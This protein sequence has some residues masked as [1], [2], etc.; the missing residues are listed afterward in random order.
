MALGFFVIIITIFLISR[1]FNIVSFLKTSS[2]VRSLARL[3]IFQFGFRRILSA[4]YFKIN[5]FG[6]SSLGL[7]ILV[8]RLLSGEVF[9]FLGASFVLVRMG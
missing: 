7:M 4:L 6:V 1:V 8:I 3:I 9:G 2:S 5:I